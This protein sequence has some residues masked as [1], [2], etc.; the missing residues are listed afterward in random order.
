MQTTFTKNGIT[1]EFYRLKNDEKYSFRVKDNQELTE[2]ILA[3]L[4]TKKVSERNIEFT[5]AEIFDKIESGQL[6]VFAPVK[7]ESEPKPTNQIRAYK[8]RNFNEFAIHFGGKECII[9]GSYSMNVVYFENIKDEIQ[10]QVPLNEF[11]EKYTALKNKI[12][13]LMLKEFALINVDFE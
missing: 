10:S 4:F 11:F 2:V 1:L 5:Q 3:N 9:V 12:E 7:T 13:G 6:T 8:L